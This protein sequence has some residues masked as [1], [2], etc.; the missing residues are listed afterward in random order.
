MGM[1]APICDIT[2]PSIRNALAATLILLGEDDYCM[3]YIEEMR[4][5]K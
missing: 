1:D 2:S 4:S 3:E 5:S